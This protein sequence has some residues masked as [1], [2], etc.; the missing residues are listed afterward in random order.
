MIREYLKV[1]ERIWDWQYIFEPLCFFIGTN[2]K[3]RFLEQ[4]VDFFKKHS[5]QLD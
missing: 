3:F 4:R 2:H 5:T 1:D